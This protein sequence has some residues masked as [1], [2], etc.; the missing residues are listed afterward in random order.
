MSIVTVVLGAGA[1]RGVS[2]SH[3]RELPSPLD[4]DYFDL[5]QRLQPQAEERE[6]IDFVLKQVAELPPDFGRSME[7]TFYTLHLQSFLRRKVS[8][9]TDKSSEARIVGAFAQAT[10]ALLQESHGESTCDYH[11]EIVRRL[12]GDDA[13]LS[14]NYD[15]VIERALRPFAE[16][17]AIAFGGSIYCFEGSRNEPIPIPKII[18][19]HGSSNWQLRKG[20]FSTGQSWTDL[21][22][23]PSQARRNSKEK[24][25][26]MF[27]P[28]WD[29]NFEYRRWLHLWREAHLQL[30]RTDVLLVWGASLSPTDV[31][32]RELFSISVGESGVNIKL[33]VIDP[34]PSTRQRWRDLYP[35]AQFWE[36]DRISKFLTDPPSWWSQIV[37]SKAYHKIEHGNG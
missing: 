34:S 3:L 30:L 5:L 1:S 19:L 10:E 12:T 25:F 27:Q 7:R 35:R 16:A 33:C 6:A 36:Y 29:R 4:S 23:G 37:I 28:F 18:K 14:F 31:E 2:Y 22:K 20:R 15:L 17:V 26:P 21:D 13:V 11:K 8:G 9:S 24:D 32:A